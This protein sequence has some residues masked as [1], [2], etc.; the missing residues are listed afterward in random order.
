MSFYTMTLTDSS[1]TM[2][3]TL[4][5]IPI[6]DKDVEGTADNTTIDGNVF[7]DYL[8]LKKQWSQKWS[9]M[10]ATTYAQLRG[11]YTRQF[12]DGEVPTYALAEGDGT[13]IYSATP[14]RLVLTDNGVID[15]CE[16][17]QNVQIKMRETTQ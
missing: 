2:T 11:F 14:V 17:R 4:L 5:E 6:E 1:D 12:T 3:M 7:T 10:D 16:T 13:P 9:I 8:W 15:N